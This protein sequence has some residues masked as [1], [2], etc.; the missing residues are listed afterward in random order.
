MTTKI[1]G[2]IRTEH[3]KGAA[4]RARNADL[5]P[6]VVYGL[7]ETLGVTVSP[8]ALTKAVTGPLRRNELLELSLKDAAGKVTTKFVMVKELQAHPIRRTAVHVDFLEVRKDKPVVAAI[9]VV[10]T[11]KSKAATAGA[12]QRLISRV[13]RVS[14]LPES[15]PESIQFDTTEAGFGVIRAKAVTLPKGLTLVGRSRCCSSWSRRRCTRSW[16]QGRCSSRGCCCTRRQEEVAHDSR[17]SNPQP[18]LCGVVS[19]CAP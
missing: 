12:A 5:V 9:P 18:R 15:I 19:L 4:R 17:S 7:G 10:L 6:G 1:E 14:V 2:T 3:G 8:K 13:L 16:C 11:G